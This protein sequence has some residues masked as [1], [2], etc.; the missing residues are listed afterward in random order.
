MLTYDNSCYNYHMIMVAI[1][2]IC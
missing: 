2:T 1:I